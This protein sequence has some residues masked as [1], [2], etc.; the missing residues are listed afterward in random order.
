MLKPGVTQ[1]LRSRVNAHIAAETRQ[2]RLMTSA[3]IVALV[4]LCAYFVL[5]WLT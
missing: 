2:R 3:V 4:A 5:R 1:E